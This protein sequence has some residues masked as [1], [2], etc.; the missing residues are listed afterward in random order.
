LTFDKDFKK[1]K[2]YLEKEVKVKVE[3]R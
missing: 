2:E 1:A 3:I